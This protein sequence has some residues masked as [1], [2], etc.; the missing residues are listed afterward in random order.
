MWWKGRMWPGRKI[1]CVTRDA[2][3]VAS[4]TTALNSAHLTLIG[5][6]GTGKSVILVG[7][8]SL[9]DDDTIRQKAKDFHGQS[10]W[11]GDS[12]ATINWRE[13]KHAPRR[14]YHWR[15]YRT[16]S[17]QQSANKWRPS[18]GGWRRIER[19]KNTDS[20]SPWAMRSCNPCPLVGQHRRTA[21]AV[22]YRWRG[23]NQKQRRERGHA[24]PVRQ[25]GQVANKQSGEHRRNKITGLFQPAVTA[26]LP[27]LLRR[28]DPLSGRFTE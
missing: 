12:L 20:Q 23:H 3:A 2:E 10:A 18:G 5:H 19:S 17:L 15:R 25:V 28:G 24:G 27:H 8:V 16:V 1:I 9:P 7:G 21:T 26:D 11:R 6:Q 4:F 22:M 13:E 14:H